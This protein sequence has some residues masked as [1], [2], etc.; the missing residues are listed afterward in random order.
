MEKPKWLL[1]TVSDDQ[2]DASDG[3]N[4]GWGSPEGLQEDPVYHNE[5][6]ENSDEMQPYYVLTNKE[7]LNET[8]TEV[9]DFV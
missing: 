3:H 8:L 7:T 4:E 9:F 6:G 5:Y 1:V 2:G